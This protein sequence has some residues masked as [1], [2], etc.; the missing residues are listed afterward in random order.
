MPGL[1]ESSTNASN[2]NGVVT[3]NLQG[4]YASFGY[5]ISDGANLSNSGK[6]VI[7][8]AAVA[9]KPVVDISLTGNGVPLYSQYP[10]SGISTGAFQ[11]GNFNKGSFG[12]TSSFTDSTTTQDSVVGTSGNDYIV[13][14]KGGGDY[15]VGGAGNDVLVGGNSTSGDTLDG[16]TGNDILVAGLGGDTCMAAQVPTWPC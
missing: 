11:S 15:F 7:D 16:G 8:I 1:N 6:L 10:S 9:D 3:G 14:I 13:S 5:Q 2:G 12:I 4:D